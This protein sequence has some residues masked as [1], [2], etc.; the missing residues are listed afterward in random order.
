M[1]SYNAMNDSINIPGFLEGGS[2]LGL[3]DEA[4]LRSALTAQRLR[5]RLEV[6]GSN[7][8]IWRLFDVESDMTIEDLAIAI[9]HIMGWSSNLEHEI[10]I[11]GVRFANIYRPPEM[12]LPPFVEVDGKTIDEEDLQLNRV[13]NTIHKHGF[14]YL[15]D[16]RKNIIVDG[17]LEDILPSI[18]YPFFPQ[19]LAGENASPP[20][21]IE[22]LEK[23]YEMFHEIENNLPRKQEYLD[24]MKEFNYLDKDIHSFDIIFV[25]QI[26][27][28]I[29]EME[30]DRQ[31][32]L[33]E[34]FWA[35]LG[36]HRKRRDED[37]DEENDD[38]DK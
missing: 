38:N 36:I 14:T 33:R 32:K 15:I 5:I 28:R 12:N 34:E 31:Q 10:H 26:T 29:F 23:F 22:S 8:R 7:P 16:P 30:Y 13:I 37:E 2:V 1:L 18:D 4:L 35:S 9:V 6:R 11:L 3:S 25:N 21:D 17:V 27:K 19:C 20:E 24:W